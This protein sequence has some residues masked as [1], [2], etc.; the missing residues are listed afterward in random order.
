MPRLR[1]PGSSKTLELFNDFTELVFQ[2]VGNPLPACGS[3]ERV[4]LQRCSLDPWP[5]NLGPVTWDLGP[6]TWAPTASDLGPGTYD[7]GPT[8]WDLWFQRLGFRVSGFM[9]YGRK[10]GSARDR[11]RAQRAA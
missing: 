3:P 1:L 10:A 11:P 9:V 7:L 4:H 8:T 5:L 2:F 6:G